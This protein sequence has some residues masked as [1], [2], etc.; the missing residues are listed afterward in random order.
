MHD[1]R[2]S[3]LNSLDRSV[4]RGLSR[5]EQYQKLDHLFAEVVNKASR[6]PNSRQY[7]FL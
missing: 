7:S 5:D 1:K 4:N 3:G 2:A 6:S